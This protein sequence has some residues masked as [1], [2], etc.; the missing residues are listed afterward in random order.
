MPLYFTFD[1]SQV[2]KTMSMAVLIHAELDDAAS[3]PTS[4]WQHLSIR[5]VAMPQVALPKQ[6]M[7]SITWSSDD[8]LLLD[9]GAEYSFLRAYRSLG[10]NTV[11]LVSMPSMFINKAEAGSN[12]SIAPGAWRWMYPSNRSGPLWQ[13]TGSQEG[14][15]LFG[16]EV[17]APDPSGGASS[18]KKPPNASLL[19]AGLTDDQAAT[20]MKKWQAAFEFSQKTNGHLDVAYDGVFSRVNTESFC[21]MMSLTRPDWAF[22]DDEAFG[23]GWGTWRTEVAQSGNAAARAM[24]GEQQED[25]AWR[26]VAELLQAWTQCLADVSPKTTVAWYGNPFPDE[27]FSDAGISM[28]PSEYGPQHYLKTFSSRLRA[29]K[30]RQ[31]PMAGGRPRHM[32][33]WL[34]ACTYGQMDAVAVLESTLHS[35]GAGATGFSFFID[36][37]FDDMGKLLALSTATALATPFEDFFFSG[38]PILPDAAAASKGLRAWSGVRKGS[39]LWVVLTPGKLAHTQPSDVHLELTVGSEDGGESQATFVA[40]DLVSGEVAHLGQGPKISVRR[41][42][43]A[44][45]V[46]HI[47][48]TAGE[49]CERNKLPPLAWVPHAPDA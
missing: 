4:D 31:S 36:S 26:M 22:M 14:A 6:L 47:G 45:T 23:E 1:A 25:L 2:G 32:L 33:P 8:S 29:A 30:Q 11:P 15:L 35:Y 27:L 46:L 24:P 20:E 7:T 17:S 5:C 40:C 10:F 3:V 41:R 28:Q 49:T 43:A 42:L 44:T 12:N 18:C 16:P 19:P 21:T 39:E 13:G 9:N 34:T 37:C 48:P 38:E